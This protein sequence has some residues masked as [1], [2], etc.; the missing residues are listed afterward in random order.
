MRVTGPS[1][2]ARGVDNSSRTETFDVRV[3]G[4]QERDT[5]CLGERAPWNCTLR[6]R[7][8]RDGAEEGHEVIGD[9]AE[10]H[11]DDGALGTR[12]D[13]RLVVLREEGVDPADSR[14]PTVRAFAG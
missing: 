10:H 2:S 7:A 9:A 14:R 6:L 3:R 1:R 12:L 13:P 8:Q 11:D 4:R 5:D